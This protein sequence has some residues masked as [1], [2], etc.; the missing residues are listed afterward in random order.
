MNAPNPGTTLPAIRPLFLDQPEAGLFVVRQ[1]EQGKK[2]PAGPSITITSYRSELQLKKSLPP[3]DQKEFRLSLQKA[4]GVGSE[5]LGLQ[6]WFPTEKGSELVLAFNPVKMINA[7][8]CAFLG[9]GEDVPQVWSDCERFYACLKG[10]KEMDTLLV[11]AAIVRKPPPYVTFFRL[12]FERDRGVY[13]SPEV[14]RA[15]GSY[16]GDAQIPP[17][18][19]RKAVAL[20]MPAPQS[21]DA[22]ALSEL[23]GGMMSLIVHLQGADQGPSAVAVLQRLHSFFYDQKEGR[24]RIAA[25]AAD[26]KRLN[27][28]RMLAGAPGTPLEEKMRGSLLQW[29]G[30]KR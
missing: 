12:L 28:V 29:L 4:E 13:G 3:I 17:L 30:G 14:C 8:D 26:E 27:A 7:K 10:G 6:E 15:A 11:A 24:Y 23:A 2:Q 1:T 21:R 16:L 18:E 20:Y 5:Q 19:R 9:A 25:P 22:A